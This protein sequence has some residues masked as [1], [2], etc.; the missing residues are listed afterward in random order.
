MTLGKYLLVIVDHVTVSGTLRQ[1][2]LL[3]SW[4]VS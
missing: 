1:R 3:G 4:L 2:L